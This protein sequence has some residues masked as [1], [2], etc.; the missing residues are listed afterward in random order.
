MACP[1]EK[2]V[3]GRG[4]SAGVQ[5]IQQLLV[6]LLGHASDPDEVP[7][8]LC[9]A[10]VGQGG[11]KGWGDAFGDTHGHLDGSGR[12][13]ENARSEIG[14]AVSLWAWN[15]ALTV[16]AVV[17]GAEGGGLAISTMS[18]RRVIPF[19]TALP[20]GEC[21][22]LLQGGE[23]AETFGK[24]RSGEEG[25]CFGHMPV[26]QAVLPGGEPQGAGRVQGGQRGLPRQPRWAAT[27][28]REPRA[29][30]IPYAAAA[31]VDAR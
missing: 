30:S 11:L 21:L 3:Q 20:A 16:L 27:V 12:A 15:V 10:C 28:T 18:G 25:D 7:L 4:S 31:P 9:D 13:A 14:E 6:T 29:R 5:A 24:V 23:P 22:G 17:A 26:L 1:V 2:T 8:A 19:V